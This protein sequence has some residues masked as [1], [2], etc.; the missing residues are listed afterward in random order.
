MQR[1][2]FVGV[3]VWILLAMNHPFA[4]S[5]PLA[6]NERLTSAAMRQQ[7]G[8]LA[9]LAQ[10]HAAWEWFT[11]HARALTELQMELTRVPAPPFGEAHRAEWLRKRFVELG[12]DEVHI[13]EAGNVLG[14]RPGAVAGSKYVAVTAH[15]DTVFP[16]GT[17]IDVRNDAGRLYGPGISDNSTG[18]TAM[19]AIISALNA[20]GIV[21]AAPI[22]FIGNVGEEGEGD[23][24]GMRY[25]FNHPRWKD[26]IAYTLVIDGGGADTII[27][28]GIG[29]RRFLATVHG[30]GGHSWSDFGTPNPITLLARAIDQFSRTPMHAGARSAFNI[31]VISGGTSVNSIPESASMKVDIR[32]AAPAELD[33]LEHALRDA[34]IHATTDASGGERKN[35]AVSYELKTIGNRPAAELNP[36]AHILEVMQAVDAQLGIASRQQRASTDANI[37]LS[38]GK[39]AIAVGGGGNGGGAHTMHEW[40]DPTNRALGLRRILLA[41]LAL[42]G[43]Q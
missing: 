36:H 4:D 33:R 30:P 2:T 28:E 13:D 41:V 25:I 18:L 37:P 32:S 19:L 29:S 27:T 11:A 12:L 14:V 16:A 1:R 7:V 21:N 10:V 26:A 9:A 34:L 6:Q 43:V 39:E 22:V 15:I 40:Y 23:L 38:L 8:R 31:G 24:R 20:A 42:S 5:R 17:P 3:V 35:A